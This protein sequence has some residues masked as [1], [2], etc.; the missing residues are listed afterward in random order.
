MTSQ[1]AAAP[2]KL[3]GTVLKIAG[4]VVLGAIM[5]I[6]DITVV[7]VALPTFQS[8]FGATYAEVAW[9]MT[10]YTLALATVIPLSGWAA[11]RFGTKRLYML[12]ILL[13]TLGSV[14][15]ATADSI[16]QLIAYRVLQGLGGGMLMPL[17]MTIMTRA[18][19]PARIGRLMAVLGI[20]MLLGPI[21]GPI[22]GGWLIDSASWHWI[23]LIN[24]P[25]GVIALVYAFFAL[26]KDAAEPSESFDF[27]GMLM[28]SPG[29][30]LFLYGVSSLPETG[31]ITATK[32]WTTMLAGA[33]LVITFVLYSFR[34]RHPLL[35]LRLFR[36]R[37]LTV[38]SVS[39]FVFIIAFMGAGLLFPSYFLQ[40]RGESTLHAGLLMAPQGIGAMLTMPIAGTLADKIPVGRT[41][42]FAMALIAAGFFTFTQVGTDTSYLLLCGSLFVMGLGMGGTMMPIMTSALRTLTPQDTARGSTLVNILQQIG[43]SVGAATMSVILTSQLNGSPVIPGLT[44]PQTGEPVT[45]AGAAIANNHGAG[46]PLPPE[47][48][49]RGLAFVADSFAT[50]F[51]VGFVLVLLTFIPIA[52][53]PRKREVSRQ[54]GAAT[55]LGGDKPAPAATMVH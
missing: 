25:I 22:L 30:A 46:I 26:P 54:G 13:F 27:I 1:A 38:A 11:D 43:S 50:T 10:G 41:V 19:G 5:S 49:A 53:L 15:C 20:P 52:F 2:D 23:F 31:T 47:V 55:E 28:L 4:V 35:D 42:P 44:D 17:G 7:S 18:A 51:W 48:F 12:A 33:I 3:D 9:T 6:L 45:E 36:N 40:V 24:L 21:G 39:L 37:S 32:V 29:L 14:L 8:E 16:G 34:P